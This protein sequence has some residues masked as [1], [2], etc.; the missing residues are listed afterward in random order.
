MGKRLVD[1]SWEDSCLANLK[2]GE[3]FFALRGNDALAAG[4]VDLWAAMA[5]LHGIH[6]GK[7]AE[8]FDCAQ[9]MRKRPIRLQQRGSVIITN[10]DSLQLLQRGEPFF[11][12]RGQDKLAAILVRTWAA[13][14]FQQALPLEEYQRALRV[15]GEMDR[16]S[17][18][19]FPD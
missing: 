7:C 11:V 4:I 8:A 9:E 17:P 10:R 1:G 19:K 3:P 18:R 15:A 16:W 13:F 14:A 5:A 6:V 12:L 2:D